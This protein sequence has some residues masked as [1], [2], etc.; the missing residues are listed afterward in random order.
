MKTISEVSRNRV[1]RER[2]VSGNLIEC[3]NVITRYDDGSFDL[4]AEFAVN[5]VELHSIQCGECAEELEQ[6]RDA[7]WK[8]FCENQGVVKS[9]GKTDLFKVENCEGEELEVSVDWVH[10]TSKERNEAWRL[11]IR[12]SQRQLDKDMRIESRET[13]VNWRGT[14]QSEGC[15]VS[16]E[17]RVDGTNYPYYP[18]SHQTTQKAILE[19]IKSSVKQVRY[20]DMT[21]DNVNPEIVSVPLRYE[22]GACAYMQELFG[23]ESSEPY[24]TS[25]VPE[26]LVA[27]VTVCSKKKTACLSK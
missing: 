16:D 12:I 20:G 18:K 14:L 5:H 4:G 19:D 7:H 26:M 2:S 15:L 6:R 22:L 11:M 17:D 27:Y 1:Y 3:F 25:D 13:G 10:A 21:T 24:E 9:C 8:G 23:G